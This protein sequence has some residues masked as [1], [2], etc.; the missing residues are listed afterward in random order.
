MGKS[1]LPAVTKE[2]KESLRDVLV[3]AVSAPLPLQAFK[4]STMP[5]TSKYFM[6]KKYGKLAEQ[7]LPQNTY[8]KS[9]VRCKKAATVFAAAVVLYNV[10]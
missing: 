3:A 8:L 10:I 9:A 5:A 1:A 4:K 2:S 7:A 6:A